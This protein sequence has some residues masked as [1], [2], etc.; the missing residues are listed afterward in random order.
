MPYL[1]CD[2]CNVYYE[3]DDDFDISELENCE[4]CGEKL[5]YYESMDEYY[6]NTSENTPK[7]DHKVKPKKETNYNLIA[8]IGLVIAIIG[9]GTF[10]LSFVAPFIFIS[11]NFDALNSTSS[12]ETSLSMISQIMIIYII[13]FI[14]MAAGSIIYLF[15]KRKNPNIKK[16]S[17][18]LKESPKYFNNFPEGYFILNKFKIQNKKIN[19]DHVIIGPTG[20]FLIKIKNF[21]KKIIVN[22][23]KLYTENGNNKSKIAGS[24]GRKLKME[25]VEFGRF[26]ASKGLNISHLMISTV[27]TFSND[28]FKIEKSPSFYDVVYLEMVPDF[29][30][31]S[32]RKMKKEDIIEV[33]VLLEPYCT[34][35]FKT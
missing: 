12:A 31:A 22:E 7:D 4:K 15:G 18:K 5:E 35:V 34:E 26:L 3:I 25:T 21:K 28:D 29:I 14:L 8:I 27:L 10:L 20:I 11:Q 2:N 33:L 23:N 30:L 16:S 1:I 13:S 24:H 6:Q 17:G 19:F 9:L 32:R